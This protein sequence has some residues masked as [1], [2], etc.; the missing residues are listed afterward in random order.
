MGYRCLRFCVLFFNVLFFFSG[1]AL[2]AFGIYLKVEKDDYADICEQYSW[3]TSANICI[4]VGAL[5][6]FISAFG[7]LGAAMRSSNILGFF[8]FLLL[9]IFVMELAAGVLAFVYKQEL[10]DDVEQCLNTTISQAREGKEFLQD[11]WKAFQEEFDCCGVRGVADWGNAENNYCKAENQTGCL[12]KFEDESSEFLLAIGGL[13][14]GVT[15]IEILGMVLAISL[16]MKIN[17]EKKD[18][19]PQEDYGKF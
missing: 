15:L 11:A 8:F 19:K 3:A 2:F 16:I 5:V 9:L 12:D 6:F 7:C 17:M 10:V 1:I 4:A 13:C 14:V 18:S